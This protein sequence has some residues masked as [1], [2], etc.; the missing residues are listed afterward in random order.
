M[1]HTEAPLLAELIGQNRLP[2]P[3]AVETPDPI[4]IEGT[5]DIQTKLLEAARRLIRTTGVIQLPEG[6]VTPTKFLIGGVITVQAFSRVGDKSFRTY[7]SLIPPD[8]YSK[9][10]GVK[11]SWVQFGINQEPLGS[12]RSLE[13]QNPVKVAV[14]ERLKLKKPESGAYSR[15]DFERDEFTRLPAEEVRYLLDDYLQSV[16][17]FQASDQHYQDITGKNRTPGGGKI[18]KLYKNDIIKV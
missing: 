1:V 16:P 10:N 18:S 9:M 2:L 4:L 12:G 11:Q 17:D 5:R 3:T 8:E 13:V 7:A 15:E 14:Y 6:A